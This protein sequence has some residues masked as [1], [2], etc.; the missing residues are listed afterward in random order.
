MNKLILFLLL[1]IAG[2]FCI[3]QPHPVEKPFG[4]FYDIND[5]FLLD[6]FD[7]DY[8]PEDLLSVS[9][10]TNED[11]LPGYYYNLDGKK[12]NGRLQMNKNF[13]EIS[14]ERANSDITST[15]NPD[16][17][18]GVVIGR[19]S[20]AVI[21]DFYVERAV[22][23]IHVK[24]KEFAQVILK[25]DN[26]TFY[27]HLRNDL[28]TT[29]LTTYIVKS[30]SSNK[31]IS[32]SQ[33]IEK[34][35]PTAM[36]AFGE[37]DLL[38]HRIRTG[39]YTSDN[40]PEMAKLLEYKRKMD[41]NEKIYFSN[42]WDEANQNNYTYYDRL[43]NLKDSVWEVS[44]HTKA[45][46]TLLRGHFTSFL[47][48]RKNG[49]FKWYYPNGKVRK[50]VCY[51]KNKP[52]NEVLYYHPNGNLHYKINKTKKGF[53]YNLVQDENEKSLINEKGNGIETIIDNV[54]NRKITR[55]YNANKVFLS[56]YNE[57]DNRII[58]QHVST[59]AKLKSFKALQDD[60]KSFEIPDTV[61]RDCSQGYL[62]LRFIIE[63]DGSISKAE[64]VKGLHSSFDGLIMTY[65]KDI[66]SWKP[67]KNGDQKIAQELIVPVYLSITSFSNI[68]E[69]YFYND[70]F[71]QMRMM[72]MNTPKFNLPTITPPRF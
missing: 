5:Q 32:F 20:F 52:G 64:I 53:I 35:I 61:L 19:D 11:Y 13:N 58:Y 66:G 29:Y 50:I 25:F 8:E 28:I 7:F 37:F 33:S 26:L 17:C 67:G 48:Q 65:L 18:L 54:L 31:Y 16:N 34:F 9:Y 6:Y 14:F 72:Q 22:G 10:I 12:I 47:P 46:D 59:A 41:R 2:N 60:L 51:E 3:A 24:G 57:G 36:A 45:G 55:V 49:E 42:Y 63:P 40:I 43:M 68:R 70:P 69:N 62:L 56:F 38:K 44:Y 23:A 21:K 1:I 71:W 30:D 4:V 27:K 39:Q 15:L